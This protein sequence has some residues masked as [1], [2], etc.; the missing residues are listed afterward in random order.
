MLA[1]FAGLFLGFF[2][3]LYF[4]FAT[5]GRQR[6]TREEREHTEYRVGPLPLN[7]NAR[8]ELLWRER[9]IGAIGWLAVSACVM[10]IAAALLLAPHPPGT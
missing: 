1:F 7:E 5:P 8:P 9:R 3:A 2:A 4:A 6:P 10:V